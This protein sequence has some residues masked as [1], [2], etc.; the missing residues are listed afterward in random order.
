[1]PVSRKEYKQQ[2]VT[3]ELGEQELTVT[4]EPADSGVQKISAASDITQAYV[5]PAGAYTGEIVHNDVNG[6]LLTVNGRKLSFGDRYPFDVRENKTTNTQDFPPAIQVTPGTGVK[7]DYE[8]VYPSGSP[9]DVSN[10]PQN[11]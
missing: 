4:S 8:I 2:P 1:M 5:F 10:F 3:V 7:W 6:G 9:V 11:P